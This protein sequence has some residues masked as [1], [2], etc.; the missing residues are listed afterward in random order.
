MA[1]M[2]PGVEFARRRRLHQGRDSLSAATHGWTRRSPFCLYTSNSENQ[3]ASIS[4]PLQRRGLKGGRD[5]DEELGIRA[6]EAKER[7]NERLRKSVTRVQGSNLKV[8]SRWTGL[9]P[10]CLS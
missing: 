5:E 10:F 4:C 2:L 6:T 3:H 1:G 7:L 8:P 9:K